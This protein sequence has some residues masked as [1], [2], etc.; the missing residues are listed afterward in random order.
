MI[1][2]LMNIVLICAGDHGMETLNYLNYIQHAKKNIFKKIYIIDK[3]LKKSK[4]FKKI[5]KN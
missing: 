5:K 2:Q 4:L 1:S 3:N